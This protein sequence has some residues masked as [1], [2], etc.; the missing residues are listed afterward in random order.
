MSPILFNL[1]ISNLL[2]DKPKSA[3]PSM[4]IDDLALS[5]DPEEVHEAIARVKTDVRKIG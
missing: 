3:K 5:V 2:R 1:A 4:F